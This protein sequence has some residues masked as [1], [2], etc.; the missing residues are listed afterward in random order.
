MTESLSPLR[1]LPERAFLDANVIRGQLTN[2]MLLT[3]ANNDVFEPRWSKHVMDEMRRNRPPGVSE[4]R[5]DRRIAM[6]N[7][8][9]PHAMTSGY[10]YLEPQMQ[11]DAKD[12]HVLAAAVHSGSDVLVSDNTKD[13]NPPSTGPNA[14]RVE[15]LSQFLIRI[16]EEDPARVQGALQEMLD[17][18]KRDPRTMPALL[19]KM[20]T[21]PELRGFAQKL[22]AVVPPEQRGSAEVLTANQ[23]G[24]AKSVALDGVAPPTGAA[25][26]PTSTPEA[27]KSTEQGQEKDVEQEH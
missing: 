2:D 10:E 21:Q 13:F 19:D 9:F 16:L 8:A 20:A 26:A 3:M 27:R 17:R 25:Q 22:N 24:S 7:K 11:A 6:M 18:N 14:M 15:K 5:I 12:K 4:E 23:R 1:S